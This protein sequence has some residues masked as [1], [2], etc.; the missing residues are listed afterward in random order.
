[1]KKPKKRQYQYATMHAFTRL[2]W[3]PRAGDPVIYR[4]AGGRHRLKVWK[5]DGGTIY[6]DNGAGP[7]NSRQLFYRTP[8]NAVR[9]VWDRLRKMCEYSEEVSPGRWVAGVKVNGTM[10]TLQ[11]RTVRIAA[12]LLE[13]RA[14]DIRINE[15]VNRIANDVRKT[16]ALKLV[17]SSTQ[18]SN[19]A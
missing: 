6:L 9:E 15:G 17:Y 2:L 7:F 19:P 13:L 3:T 14:L 4:D 11:G 12:R 16:G 5:S 1:M 8:P 10:T 18:E